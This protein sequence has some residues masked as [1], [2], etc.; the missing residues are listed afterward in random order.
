ML[1]A[2]V[3]VVVV[4]V[5]AVA[6]AAAVVVVSVVVEVAVIDTRPHAE[7]CVFFPRWPVFT[8]LRRRAPWREGSAR[9]SASAPLL[10]ALGFRI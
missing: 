5:V 8:R 3:V 2:I 7:Q 4:V 6:V 9:A 1:I 10:F